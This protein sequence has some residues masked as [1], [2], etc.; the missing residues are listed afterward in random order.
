MGKDKAI[1]I[2]KNLNMTIDKMLDKSIIRKSDNSIFHNPSVSKRVL[3]KKKDELIS[4]YNLKK[5]EYG[6]TKSEG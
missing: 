4:K 2:V 6:A 3:V 5:K 1:E